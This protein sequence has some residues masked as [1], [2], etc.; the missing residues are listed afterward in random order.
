MRRGP[1]SLSETRVLV[2]EEV[3]YAETNVS[4]LEA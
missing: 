1:F 3:S 4:A 2:V